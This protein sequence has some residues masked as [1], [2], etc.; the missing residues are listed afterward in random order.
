MTKDILKTSS[1]YLS[2]ILRH[3]PE[4]IGLELDENGWADLAAL[5][6]KAEIDLNP[7][8]ICEIV[9]TSDKQR[10]ALSADGL[11]IRGNQGHSI[12]VDLQL[13]SLKPPQVLFHGTAA[14]SLE[15]IRLHGLVKGKR[16]HVHLSKD[17]D[18]ARKVGA[19]HGRPEVLRVN[20][21]QMY[22]AGHLF[23]LSQ[24]GVWLCAHVPACYLQ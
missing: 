11:R 19:R 23:C 8:L 7:Q 24:N 13:A 22:A 12:A 4:S 6:E 1:K 15:S 10:F 5:V 17:P 21:G 16:Q 18:T 20:S 14:A 9:K 2:F 3:A